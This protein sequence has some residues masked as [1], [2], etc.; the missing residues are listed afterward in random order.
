MRAN[1]RLAAE[2]VA[3]AG[4]PDYERWWAQ[5]RATGYCAAPVRLAGAGWRVDPGTGEILGAYST[6]VEPDGALLTACGNRRAAVCPPCSAVYRADTWQLV[7][8]GLRGGNGLPESVGEHPRVFAMFTAPSFGAVHSARTRRGRARICRPPRAG[9]SP[10]CPHGRSTSC[11][12]VHRSGDAA[13]GT[14]LCGRCFDYSGAVL[15]NA[16]APELWRRTTIY[17][18]RALAARVGFTPTDASYSRHPVALF[19][20]SAVR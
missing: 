14:A 13:I 20:S 15:F 19:P 11:P 10:H 9:E 1:P 18:Y 6:R 2:L 17:L 8:A 4:A 3:R 5:V 16:L 7:A 12:Q